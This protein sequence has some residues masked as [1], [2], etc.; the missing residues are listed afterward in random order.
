[1][2]LDRHIRE[3]LVFGLD[4]GTRTIMGILGFQ[5]GNDFVVIAS[6][7]IEHESRAMMDGQIHDIFKVAQTV[8]KVKAALE[9]RLGIQLKDVAIAAAGR[10]LKTYLVRIDQNLD[11]VKEINKDVIREL[12]L[13]GIDEAQVK[14][15]EELDDTNIDYFCVG[16]SVVNYYLNLNSAS[17]F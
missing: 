15:K 10:V 1:M 2:N 11:E 7:Q 9:K 3:E 14:L 12:E 6:E 17:K 4:I 8:Q 16:Y 5:R 13:K